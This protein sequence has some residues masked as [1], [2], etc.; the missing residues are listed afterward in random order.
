MAELRREI[1]DLTRLSNIKL[2]ELLNRY[3]DVVDATHYRRSFSTPQVYERNNGRAEAR[4]ALLSA[5]NAE[6]SLAHHKLT[7]LET[8]L[9]EELTL[10]GLKTEA[11]YNFVRN[12]PNLENVLEAIQRPEIEAGKHE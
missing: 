3:A 8:Q 9:E 12:M 1:E 4:N 10:D 5:A 11:A 2:E 7:E 6:K